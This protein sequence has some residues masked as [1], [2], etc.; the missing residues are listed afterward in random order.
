MFW[1][2]YTFS[3]Y[4]SIIK[5]KLEQ[6]SPCKGR[7]ATH[8]YTKSKY[9]FK[10][11]YNRI[12]A[13]TNSGSFAPFMQAAFYLVV[14]SRVGNSCLC[15]T[16]EIGNIIIFSDFIIL[17]CLFL[18]SFSRNRALPCIQPAYMKQYKV[19]VTLHRQNGIWGKKIMFLNDANR[20][21]RA[22]GL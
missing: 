4:F 2:C 6:L 14:G 18:L 15:R 3:F 11:C 12:L 13:R 21:S 10:G 8:P 20:V 1:P 7:F 16:R 22:I 9:L 17:I 5:I 19:Y